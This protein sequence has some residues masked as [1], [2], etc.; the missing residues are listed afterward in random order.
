MQNLQSLTLLGEVRA[1]CQNSMSLNFAS[2]C[3]A[4]EA[5]AKGYGIGDVNRKLEPKPSIDAEASKCKVLNSIASEAVD[6]SG[7]GNAS[8]AV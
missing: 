8:T 4:R 2:E 1:M 6:K 7:P 3:A 5:C